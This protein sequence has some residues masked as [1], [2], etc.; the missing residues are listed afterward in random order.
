M[1]LTNSTILKVMHVLFWIV[2][3]GLCIQTGALITSFLV[4]LFVS[5]NGAKD[6]YLGLN[7]YALYEFSRVD[8]IFMASLVIAL[9]AQKAYIAFLIVKFFLKF[10]LAKPFGQELT[11]LFLRISYTALGTGVLA[12]I[13]EGYAHR[14][15]KQGI[16]VPVEWSG[17]EIL[18]FGGV[19]YLLALVYQKGTELQQENDLTV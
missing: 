18:F 10:K 7:L 19:I 5:A 17:N 12:M 11:A 8:Y 14:F 13:A 16:D 15:T 3:I 2:F 6:L 4:S 1:T 9:S